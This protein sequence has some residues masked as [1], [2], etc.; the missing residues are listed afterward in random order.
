MGLIHEL[1]RLSSS[2]FIYDNPD[3]IGWR[4]GNSIDGAP[5]VDQWNVSNGALRLIGVSNTLFV[6]GY[7]HARI[8]P[9][10]CPVC[11]APKERFEV[12]S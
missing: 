4:V 6:C 1:L 7:T 5:T 2:Q 3:S 8:A 10:V 12:I 11:G 9:E